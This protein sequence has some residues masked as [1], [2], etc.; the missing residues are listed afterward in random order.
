MLPFLALVV[1]LAVLVATGVL[2]R[3]PDPQLRRWIALVMYG[4]PLAMTLAAV[5]LWGLRRH[6]RKQISVRVQR[7][8][9]L[10]AIVVSLIAVAWIYIHIHRIAGHG[11]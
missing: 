3:M 6:D 7:R 1:S 4:A 11:V 5:T 2:T 9:A 8:Q 10:A